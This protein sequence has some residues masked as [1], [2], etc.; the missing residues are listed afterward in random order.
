MR[1]G[2]I[3]CP[4]HQTL[5]IPCYL[6]SSICLPLTPASLYAHDSACIARQTLCSFA[7]QVLVPPLRELEAYLFD[8]MARVGW[9]ELLDTLRDSAGP[10]AAEAPAAAP[11][12]GQV[13]QERQLGPVPS[14]W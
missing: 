12:F 2:T 13:N 1:P 10:A 9:R 14:R 3:R 5:S 4:A 7:S 11:A 8:T 6:R